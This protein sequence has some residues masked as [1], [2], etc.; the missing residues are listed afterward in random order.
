[1]TF[2]ELLS[3]IIA[4]HDTAKTIETCGGITTTL[5]QSDKLGYDWKNIY[6]GEVL[7]RQEYVEQENPYGTQDNPIIYLDGVPLINN[8]FYL[9]DGELYVWMEEWVKW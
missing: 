7:V 5:S 4:D 3:K 9:K 6:V 8:A 2:E 1:M